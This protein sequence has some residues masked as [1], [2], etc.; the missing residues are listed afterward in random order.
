[1]AHPYSLTIYFRE[2]LRLIIFSVPS[3]I[4][5]E[6]LT[7]RTGMGTVGARYMTLGIDRAII[8][9]PANVVETFLTAELRLNPL[10]LRL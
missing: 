3:A 2:D 4:A 8:A 1:M 7:A 6:A 5:T 10:P 9:D